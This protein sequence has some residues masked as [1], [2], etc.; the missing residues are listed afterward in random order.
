MNFDRQYLTDNRRMRLHL[1]LLPG[2]AWLPWLLLLALAFPLALSAQV[3]NGYVTAGL[4]HYEGKTNS[5]FALGGEWVPGKRFGVGGEVGVLAGHTSLI[6]ASVDGYFHFPT[7]AASRKLDPFVLAGFGGGSQGLRA[8]DGVLLNFGGG[9]NYW[10]RPRL[11]LRM[12]V[13]DMVAPNPSRLSSDQFFG[14]R[15]GLAFH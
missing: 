2:P 7:A 14:F 6:F 5:Q 12:E 13:R 9:I 8:G 10:F 1:R 15:V 4:G 11:G 3:S